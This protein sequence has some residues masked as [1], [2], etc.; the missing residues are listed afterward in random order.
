MR[1]RTTWLKIA[2]C[3]LLVLAAAAMLAYVLANRVPAA[4]VPAQLPPAQ[5]DAASKVFY[6]RVGDFNN[7]VQRNAPFT[8]RIGED[9]INAYLASLD[10]I[11]A[12]HPSDSAQDAAATRTLAKAGLA[13][14][15]VSLR[16]GALTLMVR[17]TQ[18][19]KV[20][21]ASLH[22]E[23]TP[24]GKLRATLAETA[25]GA[26]PLPSNFVRD[27]LAALARPAAQR[28][29]ASPPF[30]GE[31]HDV[32][33]AVLAALDGREIDPVFSWRL[34]T[35]KVVRVAGIDINDGNMTVRLKPQSQE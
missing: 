19:D 32:L 2:A 25:V 28:G 14:P 23:I 31:A 15:V 27:K 11:A 20:L 30:G 13:E 1:E 22:L 6:R 16:D 21:S 35:P 26:L 5:R 24:G 9:E 7:E 10:E 4:Y 33:S 3:L 17:S 18:Y 34:S 12:M 29:T 8:W